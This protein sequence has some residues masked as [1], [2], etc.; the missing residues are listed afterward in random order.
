MQKISA[1]SLND[2][3]QTMLLT[4]YLRHLESQRVDSLLSNPLYSQLV[5]QIEY[6]FSKWNGFDD[7][8][9]FLASRTILLDQ[10][11]TEFIANNHN[12]IVIS[13]A[14]GLGISF[15]L[16]TN[17]NIDWY[18][19]DLP[20]VIELRQKLFCPNDNHH[21]IAGSAWDFSWMDSIPKNRPILIVIEG[22]LLYF[23]ES[24]IKSLFNQLIHRLESNQI[25]FDSISKFIL[26]IETTNKPAYLDWDKTPYQWG[27]DDVADIN[28]W[29]T[30]IQLD[31]TLFQTDLYGN[32]CSDATKELLKSNPHGKNIF[33]IA[34]LNIA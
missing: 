9:L 15:T 28:N 11:I 21:F 7:L 5:E 31:K 8:Q 3:S 23:D 14:S 29:D 30:K 10:M 16:N 13:I 17:P 34:R 12:G 27:I 1:A 24:E 32:R 33:R 18:D 4:L 22:L 26:N 6:D 2:I 20:S 25:I 19:L